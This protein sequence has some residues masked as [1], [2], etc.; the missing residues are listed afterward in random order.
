M[1]E[2]SIPNPNKY[3]NSDLLL[4]ETGAFIFRR[5]NEWFI[6]GVDSIEEAL[7]LLENH[8]PEPTAEPTIEEKLASVGLNLED[9]KAALGL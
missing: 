5:E 6:S 9:L 8:N 2:F 7:E 4:R 1:A 3:V